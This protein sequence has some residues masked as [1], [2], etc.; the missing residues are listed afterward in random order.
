MTERNKDNIIIR[1]FLLSPQKAGLMLII[2]PCVSLYG[3]PYAMAFTRPPSS[4]DKCL[5]YRTI[6]P[7]YEMNSTEKRGGSH[8]SCLQK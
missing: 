3:S 4:K 6:A 5:Y 2:N 7:L 1:F 8:I